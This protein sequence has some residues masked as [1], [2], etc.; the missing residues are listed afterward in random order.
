MLKTVFAGLDLLIY[1][2]N[3]LLTMLKLAVLVVHS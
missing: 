3:Y 1:G 2:A